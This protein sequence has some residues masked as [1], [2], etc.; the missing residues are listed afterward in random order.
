MLSG[1]QKSYLRGLANRL[2]KPHLLGKGEVDEA[3]LSSLSAALEAN[4]L[5]KVKLLQS[6]SYDPKTLSHELS[7]ALNAEEVQIMGRVICLYR[8]SKKHPRITLPE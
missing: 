2:N 5:I 4:E 1:K 6:S 7:S 8:R 3:F